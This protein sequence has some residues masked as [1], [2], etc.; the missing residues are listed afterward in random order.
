MGEDTTCLPGIVTTYQKNKDLLP[1]DLCVAESFTLSENKDLQNIAL[2][3]T[4]TQSC[5][6]W[7]DHPHASKAIDGN[8]YG[9]KNYLCCATSCK[10]Y[11]SWWMVALDKTYSIYEIVVWARTSDDCGD[12]T[13]C[14]EHL[15][16]ANVEILLCNTVVDTK[17]L[18][19]MSQKD[20]VSFTYSGIIGDA[21]RVQHDHTDYIVLA[22]VQ[23]FGQASSARKTR[24]NIAEN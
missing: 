18:G 7:G 14:R 17:H 1:A 8:T 16:N 10:E 23:V 2:Q 19:N 21:V 15:N 5:N 11:K 22:E 24:K 12:Q 9:G 6:S 4:A 3:G 20:Q 13:D